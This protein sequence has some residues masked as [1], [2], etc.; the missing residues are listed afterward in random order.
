MAPSLDVM[1]TLKKVILLWVFAIGAAYMAVAGNSLSDYSYVLIEG[2]TFRIYPTYFNYVLVM[3]EEVPDGQWIQYYEEK[4]TQRALM[5]SID[6]GEL[7][8]EILGFHTND[9]R[10][11][12]G[13]YTKGNKDQEWAWWNSSGQI[14]AHETWK[15]GKK[16]GLWVYYNESSKRTSEGYFKDDKK[17][18]TWYYYHKDGYIH[19]AEEYKKGRLTGKNTTYTKDGKIDGYG[20]LDKD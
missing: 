17:H 10:M 3:N 5:F 12:Q 4:P 20:Y 2:D 1:N 11:L 13:Y 9:K 6:N 15:D 19:Y 18:G 8:G 7:H 14:E 16:D